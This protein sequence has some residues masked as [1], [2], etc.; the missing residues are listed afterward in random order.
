MELAKKQ[1]ATQSQKLMVFVLT[2]ALYGLATLFTELIPSFQVGVV[3]FSVASVSY[4]HL[5]VYKRQDRDT[6]QDDGD[7]CHIKGKRTKPQQAAHNG[8]A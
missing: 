5:D 3:E 4:T 1:T 6:A 2:M 8:Y 7:P